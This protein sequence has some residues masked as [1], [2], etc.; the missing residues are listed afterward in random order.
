MFFKGY[1]YLE[2]VDSYDLQESD[3]DYVVEIAQGL[4]GEFYKI[5]YSGALAAYYYT[6]V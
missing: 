4:D 1:G 3:Y 6:D 2:Y 5:L